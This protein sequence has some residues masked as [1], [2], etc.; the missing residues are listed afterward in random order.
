MTLFFLTYMY[1]PKTKIS[2]FYGLPFKAIDDV[3]CGVNG[4][5]THDKKSTEFSL[6][7][8]NLD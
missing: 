5:Y 8:L 6:S 3:K 2:S 7:V 4:H 1:G